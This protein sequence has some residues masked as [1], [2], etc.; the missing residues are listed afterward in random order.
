MAGSFGAA[1]EAIAVPTDHL[2]KP[3]FYLGR[4]H[5]TF[6]AKKGSDEILLTIPRNLSD[7][8]FDKLLQQLNRWGQLPCM[9]NKQ[10][11]HNAVAICD[12][13]GN[14]HLCS[15]LL[16]P[17]SLTL[18]NFIRINHSASRRGL[19]RGAMESLWSAMQQ[20]I[21]TNSTIDINSTRHLGFDHLGRLNILLYPPK[22]DSIRCNTVQ[23]FVL[24]AVMLFVGAS[25]I[26][27]YKLLYKE[28]AATH[29]LTRTLRTIISVAEHYGIESLAA[30]CK[31][32]LQQASFDSC[33]EALSR[34]SFEP[35]RPLPLLNNMLANHLQPQVTT[36]P[37]D[38]PTSEDCVVAPSTFD[39]ICPPSEL[40]CRA[41]KEGFWYYLTTESHLI[42]TE[43]PLLA[44]FDFYEGRAVVRTKRGYGV[45]NRQGKWVMPDRWDDIAWH[46]PE[47]IIT[48][49][50]D[51]LWHI[52]NRSG[53]QLSVVGAEWMGD[54]SE[55]FIVA[56][57]GNKFA[58]Y[59]TSGTQLTDYIYS[60]AHS[61]NQGV[62]LVEHRGKHYYIDTSF[63][64]LSA[65]QQEQ[66]FA[67]K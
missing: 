11:L 67:N 31:V 39:E 14:P 36:S 59:S 46:G 8:W 29:K 17:H 15:L 57:R 61:F 4:T 10:L 51:N 41:Y 25:D 5:I 16:E 26:E 55:G 27:A 62:A 20:I 6:L 43:R 37:L 19:I 44:A 56:R 53:R 12:S 30:L 40:I 13:Y 2:G 58:Y 65:A 50:S 28:L 3:S 60:Q 64:Q 49:A 48:A 23:S 32:A 52:Y 18:H 66:L 38:N 24:G 21:A 47:N 1:L 42:P 35:F 22:N 54:A 34:L 7:D 33:A 9:A 45:I 63:H